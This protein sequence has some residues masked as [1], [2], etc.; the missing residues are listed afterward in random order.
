MEKGHLPQTLVTWLIFLKVHLRQILRDLFQDTSGNLSLIQVYIWRR[1]MGTQLSLYSNF[2]CFYTSL[3]P[4]TFKV[5]TK[6]YRVPSEKQKTFSGFYLRG[7]I[8]Q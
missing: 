5:H 3:L 4:Q 2:S 8:V 6:A 1:P 7:I